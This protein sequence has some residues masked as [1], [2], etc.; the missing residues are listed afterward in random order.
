MKK[1]GNKAELRFCSKKKLR[2]PDIFLPVLIFF[3]SY[4]I[5]C[6]LFSRFAFTYDELAYSA[7]AQNLAMHGGWL[8]FSN[9]EDLFFFPPLFNWLSGILVIFGIERIVAVRTVTMLIS[10]AIP[11]LIYF[12]LRNYGLSTRKSL[13]GP[14]FWI[15]IPGVAFYS[16]VGQ[17]ETP[18][19]FF[20]LLSAMLLQKENNITNIILSAFFLSTAVWIKETAIG[21]VPVFFAVSALE[22]N[23]KKLFQWIG[24]FIVFCLPLFLRSLFSQEYGLFYELSNDVILWRNID[25]LSPFRSLLKLA[26]FSSFNP[27]I[28]LIA[29]IFCI[30]AVVG[31]NIYA[32]IK[33]NN[34]LTRFLVFSNLLFLIF[35]A[36]F[37]KKFD[38]YLLGVLL[39]TIILTVAVYADNRIIM[40]LIAIVLTVFSAI[41]LQDRGS[42]W[43]PYLEAVNIIKKVA[44][45]DPGATIGTPF[46]ETVRYIAETNS[47]DIKTADLPFTGP[48]KKSCEARRDKCITKYD[49][50]FTDDLFF[51]VLFC[52]SWPI[53]K[54]NCD[55]DAMKETFLQLEKVENMTIFKLY[56]VTQHEE[57][58]P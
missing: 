45:K 44:E 3:V 51:L 58:T 15:L 27:N 52:R 34:S 43:G 25:F 54:E 20:V 19:L 10:S 56:R 36:V 24:L 37:P 28:D 17:V 55:L 47:L 42:N 11:V 5:K 50:F 38:Y 8:N 32:L 33:K 49:Y 21:F 57:Q 6:L 22:K 12:V 41:G 31:I 4:F 18:F 9:S 14:V 7:T 1:S 40:T 39:F 16:T 46:P 2:N 48:H 30:L 53:K 23:L 35:F 29:V 13:S 26:G